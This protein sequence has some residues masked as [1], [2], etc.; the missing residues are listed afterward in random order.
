[1][2]ER[3]AEDQDLLNMRIAFHEARLISEQLLSDGLISF[4]QFS[5][6]MLGF[7]KKLHD[8]GDEL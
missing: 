2:T 4:E 6:L 3:R 1:M 7:E 8:L 5:Y